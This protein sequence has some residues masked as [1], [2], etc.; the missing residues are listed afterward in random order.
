MSDI[1]AEIG[2]AVTVAIEPLNRQLE[3][4]SRQMEQIKSRLDALGP[5]RAPQLVSLD[6]AAEMLG[7][8]TQTVRRMVDTRQIPYVQTAPGSAKRIKLVDLETWISRNTV[9]AIP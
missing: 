8:S 6:R 3:H 1:A 5:A 2:K 4:L 7:V 9:R